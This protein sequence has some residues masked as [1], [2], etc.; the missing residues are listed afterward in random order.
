[1]LVFYHKFAKCARHFIKNL[2]LPTKSSIAIKQ[3]LL[4][5]KKNNESEY[6]GKERRDRIVPPKSGQLER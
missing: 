4:A 1:M 5:H 2:L 6:G 3:L